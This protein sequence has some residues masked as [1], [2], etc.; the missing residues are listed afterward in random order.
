MVICGSLAV[1][2]YEII[3]GGTGSIIHIFAYIE[4]C[5]IP[6]HI[7]SQKQIT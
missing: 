4:L 6:V 3:R 5:G 1:R 2:G 7:K